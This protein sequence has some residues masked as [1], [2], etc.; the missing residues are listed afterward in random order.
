MA[1]L[2]QVEKANRASRARRAAE[3]RAVEARYERR[4]RR[5]V[6]RLSNRIDLAFSPDDVEGL[7]G[8]TSAQ[9]S[10]VEISP[11]GFGIYFPKLDADIYIPGLL[12][13]ALGSQR[14]MASRLGAAGGSVRSKDKAESARKNGRLGGRPKKVAAVA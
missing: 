5:V 10:E 6:I 9:L 2:D 1:Q 4:T 3:P 12:A 13:G 7:E 11:S 14:W 8:A